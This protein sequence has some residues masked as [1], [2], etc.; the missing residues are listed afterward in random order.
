[1]AACC[2]LCQAKNEGRDGVHKTT[3]KKRQTWH[4]EHLLGVS[5]SMLPKFVPTYGKVSAVRVQSRSTFERVII[6][7]FTSLF[8]VLLSVRVTLVEIR[9]WKLWN[10]AYVWYSTE[11]NMRGSS[12]GPDWAAETESVPMCGGWPKDVQE[13]NLLLHKICFSVNTCLLQV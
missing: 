2:S 13:Y 3:Q 10:Y 12:T 11:K 1:M 8:Y 6:T 9:V 7:C 4:S 5:V